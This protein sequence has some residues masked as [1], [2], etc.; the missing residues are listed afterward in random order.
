MS[1]TFPDPHTHRITANILAVLHG[2]DACQFILTECATFLHLFDD[3]R[4]SLRV[5]SHGDVKVRVVL[6]ADVLHKIQC[7]RKSTR[8]CFPFL[9]SNRG[10]CQSPPNKRIGNTA[11]R[12]R[13]R[14]NPPPRNAKMLVTPPFFAPSRAISIFSSGMLVLWAPVHIEHRF[15]ADAAQNFTHVTRTTS[16][17]CWF[18]HR[19]ASSSPRR[20]QV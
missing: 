17:A 19:N 18:R 13:Q 20:V 9:R 16:S 4:V 2:Y 6:F 10:V 7:T 12:K 11:A 15:Q 8:N 1:E 5:A 14:T 3:S